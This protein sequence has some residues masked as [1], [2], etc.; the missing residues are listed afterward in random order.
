MERRVADV[1]K[2]PRDEKEISIEP[3]QD[4]SPLGS[5][6]EV[7]HGSAKV[8]KVVIDG[9]SSFRPILSAIST[10]TYKLAKFLVPFLERLTTNDYPTTNSFTFAEELQSFDFKSVMT[11]FQ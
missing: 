7:M 9:L 6:R 5:R 3:Y 8:H 10:P 4:L 2:N 11:G 1:F